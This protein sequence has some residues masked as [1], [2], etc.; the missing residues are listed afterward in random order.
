[1]R[2]RPA[3][4]RRGAWTGA[5]ARLLDYW[6]NPPAVLLWLLLAAVAV[7]ALKGLGF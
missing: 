2:H 7:A 4:T 5:K 6:D 3:R 1:M